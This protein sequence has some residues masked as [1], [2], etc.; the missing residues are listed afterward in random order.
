MLQKHCFN[1]SSHQYPISNKFSMTEMITS[2]PE[3]TQ[4]LAEDVARRVLGG[5]F[6]RVIGLF[7][8]LG[9]G[10]TTFAQG[11]AKGLGIRKNIISP[12]YVF[13]RRYEL[14]QENKEAKKQKTVFT[15]FYHVDAYRISK[16][17]RSKKARKQEIV[18]LGL[19]EMFF[20]E[21][22]VVLIEWA[23]N[24]ETFL[25]KGVLC[26][27]FAHGEKENE[28]VIEVAKS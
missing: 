6:P 15:D 10:K 16:K 23:E 17:Q 21:R 7:G 12:T 5:E 19:E 13:V 20:D 27:E 22:A 1:I 26:I 18:G 3:E 4:R 24:V 25:P 8:D 2:S 14:R 9:A 11:F 28:R